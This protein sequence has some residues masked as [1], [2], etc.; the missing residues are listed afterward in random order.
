MRNFT[1]F[2][3]IVMGLCVN[4]AV[5]NAEVSEKREFLT[6]TESVMINHALYKDRIFIDS[7]Q[8]KKY[9]TE[10]TDFNSDSEDGTVLSAR[11]NGNTAYLVS[12]G[13][14]YIIANQSFNP[15]DLA[16]QT[17]P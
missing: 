14:L 9:A 11:R 17:F 3:A 16:E 12:S 10:S 8:F 13:I 7:E 1:A 6:G 5:V 15:S 4:A 2:V